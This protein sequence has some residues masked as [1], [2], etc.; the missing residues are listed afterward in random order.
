M[1]PSWAIPAG[2]FMTVRIAAVLAC[3]NRKPMTLACLDALRRQRDADADVHPYVLD[4]SSSDGTPEAVKKRHPDVTL[5]SGDGTLFWNGGMR[6]AFAAALERDYDSYLWLNDDTRLDD[7]ALAQ[8]LGT[9]EQLVANGEGEAIVAGSTRDPDSGVVTYGG[10]LRTSP[11]RPLRFRL[12]SPGSQPLPC[13]TMNG[14]C[15]LIPRT[16]ARHLGNLDPGFTHSLGDWDYG[17]RARAAGFSVWIAPGTLATCSHNPITG[18]FEDPPPHAPLA[19]V[20]SRREEGSMLVS[21]KGLP[22]APWRV[23]ARRWAG[24]LWPLYWL[25]PYV[26]RSVR[27]LAR[28]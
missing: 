24:P 5:L 26:R 10:V 16:I 13:D 6:R 15:V 4:D 14:N 3:H 21:P 2:G 18:Y 22:P 20:R 1:R 28:R 17:L 7:D 27:I 23:Y 25:S 8:L 19:R 12:I 11:W 9:H